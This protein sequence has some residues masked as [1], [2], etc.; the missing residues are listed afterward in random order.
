VS[1]HLARMGLGALRPGQAAAIGSLLRGRDV[2]VLLA[3]GGGKSL[4]YQLP[5]IELHEAGR[6]PTLVVS[7]L[8][9]LMDDQVQ[10]LERRGIRAVALHSRRKL[11]ASADE[12]TLIYASP[13]RLKSAS[14]R[15]WLRG[16]VAAV[17]I[18]EAHCISQWGHDF[19]P[20]YRKLGELKAELGVPIIALTA[21]ATPRV[22]DD[23]VA[24][25]HLDDPVRVIGD[26]RRSNLELAVE[27]HRG[28]N[29]RVERAADLLRDL[30]GRAIVYA[31][32]RKR[33]QATAEA[34]K[35]AGIDAGYYHAGRTG[36]AREKAA[37]SF[38]SGRT[39][40]LVATTAYGMGV[41]LPDVRQVIHVQA[42][43][44][45]EG[46]WQEAGRAG[47]DGLPAACVLLWSDNDAVTQARLR[48]NA[49]AP[50]AV[51]GWRALEAFVRGTGCREQAIVRYFG[52]DDVPPCGRCDVCAAPEVV[53]EMVS[54][55][56]SDA[57]DRTRE[58]VAKSAADAA[59]TL[60]DGAVDA[61]IAFI[62]AMKRPAGKRL[63]AQ[64]LRGST[65]KPVKRRGLAS[66]PGY[67]ALR[68][69][70]EVAIVGAIDRLLAIGRLARRGKRYPTVWIPDKPV[71]AKAGEGKPKWKP[72]GLAAVL[73]DF[74][75]REARKRRWKAYQVFDNA[76][77][78]AI[79][80]KR[81][82][83]LDELDAVPGMGPARLA[84]FGTK[85]LDLIRETP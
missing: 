11:D 65:A 51:E 10:A 63:V 71:R 80:S 55:S 48:G 70:P 42:P 21:T 7:P 46:W 45:L 68:S 17:A 26:L 16:R 9:A 67:G 52:G 64:G 81:P 47:R 75:K 66:N 69:V 74:R 78:I 49:P 8:I 57:A 22:A 82:Q 32:T 38:G 12:A 40:V 4:C 34:L 83:T 41:D 61:V 37:A 79:A 73:K 44:S 62:A 36:G 6:G 18:D 2:L 3:T 15:R 27:H 59:V 25:L 84:K 29:A 60:D 20:D 76:T 13:E 30:D 24:S 39:N 31:S 19:R 23:I 56:A 43:G 33:V 85:I 28:D 54:Q 50:G 72:V 35:K 14:F 58:R 53:R 5:A 1:A 77:L